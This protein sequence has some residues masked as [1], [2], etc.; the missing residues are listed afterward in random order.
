MAN[1]H[2]ERFNN[3]SK[4]FIIGYTIEHLLRGRSYHN[5]LVNEM[6]LKGNEKILDFGSG[7]GFLGKSIAKKLNNGGTITLID[8]SDKLVDYSKK[9][10]RKFDNIIYL[11][12]DIRKK[13]IQKASFDYV[14][15]TWVFHHIEK[16]NRD[17][18]INLLCQLVKPKGKMLI[19]EFSDDHSNHSDINHN[20]FIQTFENNGF[21][22]KIVFK[23][24]DG[25][26]YEFSKL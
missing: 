1:N 13:D 25:I 17:E 26:L 18:T 11:S 21:S 2:Q 16:Q 3:P 23:K 6:K 22:S 7:L 10:L 4:L 5:R 20:E 14:V 24:S 12:G 8:L 9:K 19:I 15:S